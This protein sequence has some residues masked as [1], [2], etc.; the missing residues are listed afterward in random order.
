MNT[1]P[2]EMPLMPGYGVD[3][4]D[5]E[6]LPWSWVAARLIGTRNYWVVTAS[7][8]GQPHSLPVWGVWNDS[9]QRFMF[10]CAHGSKKARNL[11]SN[12][13]MAFTNGDTVECISVQGAAELVVE[14][15]RIS[16]WVDLYVTKYG[17][18]VGPGLGDFVRQNA[19]YEVTPSLAFAVIER[20][21]EFSTRATR[22][23]FAR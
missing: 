2:A 1:P 19:I 14:P 6:G 22:W 12:P 13:R 9:S 20:A 18:E 8:A 17:D 21:D 23:R 11:G 16:L 4:P 5:W 10:S 3:T 15:A 7:A